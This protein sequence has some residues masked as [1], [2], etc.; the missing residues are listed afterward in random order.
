LHVQVRRVT[1][2]E[3]FPETEMDNRKHYKYGTP[4]PL[5][6][7]FFLCNAWENVVLLDRFGNKELLAEHALLPC[8]P[9]ERLRIIDPIPM[10]SRPA[11]PVIPPRTQPADTRQPA[12]I[13]VMNVYDSDLPF[14]PDA[15]IKWLR[16][17]QNILKENHLMG[18]PMIGYERENTPRIPLGIVPVEADGSAYFEAPAAKELILQVLDEDYRAIQSMRSVAFV[19]PGEHLTC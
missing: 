2:D 12:T 16:V 7:D 11:P 18:A 14:P 9:D 8:A 1:P 6:E 3:P 4:W 19:H 17:T 15:K 5:S 13:A 10:R